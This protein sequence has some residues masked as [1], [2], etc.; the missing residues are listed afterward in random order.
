MSPS[1]SRHIVTD[2]SL[3]HIFH[4]LVI[5]REIS[6]RHSQCANCKTHDN[7]RQVQPFRN[8]HLADLQKSKEH[9]HREEGPAKVVHLVSDNGSFNR[10]RKAQQPMAKISYK[11]CV[12]DVINVIVPLILKT[13]GQHC[14]IDSGQN[15]HQC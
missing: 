3:D 10:F 4:S 15:K 11:Y 9:E 8:T 2:T 12:E 13:E 1:I 7:Q 5:R 6:D 14:Q